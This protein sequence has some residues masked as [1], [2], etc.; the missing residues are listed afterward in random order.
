MTRVKRVLC[1]LKCTMDC[2]IHYC[3]GKTGLFGY[4]DADYAQMI[5]FFQMS[6]GPVSWQSQK[7][8]S[9]ALSTSEAEYILD[10][11]WLRRLQEDWVEIRMV[12][13]S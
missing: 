10:A 1:Y 6:R 7:R 5:A 2:D 9:V 13:Q 3:D 11:I 4:S 8:A 12:Q